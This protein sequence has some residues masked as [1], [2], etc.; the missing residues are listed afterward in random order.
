M[1]YHVPSNTIIFIS[2]ASG[3]GKTTIAR[4]ILN[5]LP[6]VLI[7]EEIDIIREVIR[8]YST[9]I[10]ED[11]LC[12]LN[13]NSSVTNEDLDNILNLN[14]IMKSTSELTVEEI[15]RQSALLVKPIKTICER[16]QRKS[17]PAIIE[18]TN[19]SF[20]NILSKECEQGYFL[21][22]DNMVFINLY[23][24]DAMIHK[25]RFD[26]RSMIRN[27]SPLTLEKFQN[28]RKSNEYF[29]KQ[30]EKCLAYFNTCEN[31]SDKGCI[32]KIFNIDTTLMGSTNRIANVIA[33]L[34]CNSLG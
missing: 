34:I 14:L 4:S 31:E 33:K 13:S 9:D 12:Y 32:Q 11:I 21:Q 18:G 8:N 25:K 17:I 30:T 6:E 29:F 10:K 22:S 7:I 23:S 16:L 19:I 28:I 24:S 27:E 3:V 2:G 26:M 1:K 20:K 5:L 15:E